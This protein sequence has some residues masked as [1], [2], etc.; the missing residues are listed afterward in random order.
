MTQPVKLGP[1]P[2]ARRGGSIDTYYH[3]VPAIVEAIHMVS[4]SSSTYDFGKCA[5]RGRRTRSAY[6]HIGA[7]GMLRWPRLWGRQGSLPKVV[8]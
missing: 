8:L 7:R 5:E 3:P 4:N 6:T 1:S 2:A